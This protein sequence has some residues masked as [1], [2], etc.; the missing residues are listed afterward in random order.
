MIEREAWHLSATDCQRWCGLS[1]SRFRALNIE[2]VARS[3]R[4]TLFD[5]RDVLRA[6]GTRRFSI[7]DDGGAID[8]EAERAGL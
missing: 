6:D 2:P 3:G 4:K 1:H 5:V 8:I 7:S